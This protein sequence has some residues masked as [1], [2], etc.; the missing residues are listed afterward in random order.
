M[1]QPATINAEAE[2]LRSLADEMERNLAH[3][4]GHMD[5]DQV[6]EVQDGIAR[7]REAARA[8]DRENDVRR[9]V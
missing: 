1:S 8:I 9:A 2:R 4:G 6:S 5:A 3:W 7:L